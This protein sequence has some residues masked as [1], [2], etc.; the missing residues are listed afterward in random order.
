MRNTTF[1]L[2]NQA[3]GMV[4]MAMTI[5]LDDDE[6]TDEYLSRVRMWSIETG[7]QIGALRAYIVRAKS[8]AAML[9]A[10]EKRLADRRRAIERQVLPV[11]LEIKHLL[12][13]AE[14]Q[15]GEAKVKRPDFTAYLQRSQRVDGP[16]HVADWPER[17]VVISA[18]P[19]RAAAKKALKKGHEEAGFALIEQ[20]SVVIK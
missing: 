5:E 14:L 13:A 4:N 19:D 3:S 17:W 6:A 20:R 15:T 2:L 1:D 9:R 12:E 18:R 16:A 8:D 11:K 7:D 10:E